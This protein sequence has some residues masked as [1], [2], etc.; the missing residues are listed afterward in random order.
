M[1]CTQGS[2]LHLRG[3]PDEAL[4]VHPIRHVPRELAHAIRVKS[5]CRETRA[6][7]GAK[8]RFPELMRLR[9]R[10]KQLPAVSLARTEELHVLG[11]AHLGEAGAVTR[12]PLRAPCGQ[13][14]LGSRKLGNRLPGFLGDA[15]AV[16]FDA[17]REHAGQL[18]GK[19]GEA[20]IPARRLRTRSGKIL[21]QRVRSPRTEIIL[22][23]R[24]S[25]ERLLFVPL[26][27]WRRL[28]R[29]P[30]PPELLL[31]LGEPRLVR[32]LREQH[33]VRLRRRGQHACGHRLVRHAH[34]LALVHALLRARQGRRHVLLDGNRHVAAVK[35]DVRRHD[36]EEQKAEDLEEQDEPLLPRGF[37]RVLPPL[38]LLRLLGALRQLSLP[39]G[40]VHC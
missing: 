15:C 29:S 22:D 25:C 37:L 2:E 16:V 8:A 32:L 26:L 17:Q 35:R 21:P 36:E 34:L 11:G 38:R 1:D 12:L 5:S 10:R 3:I 39:I 4:L 9:V 33:L 27:A 31:R 6:I 23:R 7:A 24:R 18:P 13:D 14:F 40:R 19:V 28:L 30:L 20:R